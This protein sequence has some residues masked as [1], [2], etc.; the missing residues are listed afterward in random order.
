M[1]QRGRAGPKGPAITAALSGRNKEGTYTR[2]R[3]A[4]P[5]VDAD[6]AYDDASEVR[7]LKKTLVGS[8]FS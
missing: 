4:K 1:Q 3:S 7:N 5:S 8:Y 2:E 6:A